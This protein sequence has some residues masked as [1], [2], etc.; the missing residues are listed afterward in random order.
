[1]LLEQEDI[2]PF[3][4][5]SSV[6]VFLLDGEIIFDDF[7]EPLLAESVAEASILLSQIFT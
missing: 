7:G 5:D 3:K 6:L 4:V 2:W 1:M